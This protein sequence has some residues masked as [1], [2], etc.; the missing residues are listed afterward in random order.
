MAQGHTALEIGTGTGYS[1]TL[2]YERLGSADVTSIEADPHR[3]E[4]T[5]SAL[6]ACRYTPTLAVADSLYG[7]WPE[8]KF[9][10]IVAACSFRTVPRPTSPR[11]GPAGRSRSLRLAL[12]IRPPPAH[13]RRGRHR[14]RP[15]AARHRVPHARPH[16][17]GADVRQPRPLGRGPAGDRPGAPALPAADHSRHRGDLPPAVPRPLRGPGRADDHNGRRAAPGRRRHQLRRHPHPPRKPAGGPR[18]R[19]RATVGA[20]R[21]RAVRVRRG[22]QAGPGDVHPARLRRRPAPTAPQLPGLPL[23]RP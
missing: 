17:R 1:T 19:P 13:R 23:P 15:A 4:Q 22:G 21:A 5:A 8:A 3:L 11:P 20:G 10:R 2:A 14:P 6:H 12:R 18:G 16:P 7:Y 9:D